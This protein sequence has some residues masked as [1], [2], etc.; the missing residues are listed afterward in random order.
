MTTEAEKAL[1]RIERALEDPWYPVL[2]LGDYAQDF[3]LIADG[4]TALKAERDEARVHAGIQNIGLKIAN[5]DCEARD[6]ELAAAKARIAELEGALR[7]ARR[8]IGD[9]NAPYDCYATGP[10][11]GDPMADLVE[12]PACSFLA[13][14]AA[15][16]SK[17]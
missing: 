15:L 12:C 1:E 5:D 4:F 3:R 8:A 10:L 17:P 13:N 16:E 11:T 2:N 6:T 7:S 14:V 9:H